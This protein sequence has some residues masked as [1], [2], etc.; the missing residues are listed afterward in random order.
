MDEVSD[1]LVLLLMNVGVHAPSYDMLESIKEGMESSTVL[2]VTFID[3]WHMSQNDGSTIDL[4]EVLKLLFE[5]LKHIAWVIELN[6][7]L[8]VEL[9]ADI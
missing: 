9:V 5:P 4:L 6:H 2:A 7:A 3:V 1:N 8:P